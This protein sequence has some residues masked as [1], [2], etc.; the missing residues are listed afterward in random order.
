LRSAFLATGQACATIV[1]K[2]G[3][4]LQFRCREVG[5]DFSRLGL[6]T[7]GFPAEARNT[8]YV[9]LPDFMLRRRKLE[10]TM[11][12]IVPSEVWTASWELICCSFTALAAV[13][14]CLWTLR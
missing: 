12:L 6:E 3:S 9:C 11:H 2:L 10:Y 1:R 14:S 8:T 5:G 7:C 4:G 13:C